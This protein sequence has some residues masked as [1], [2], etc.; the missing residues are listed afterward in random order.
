MVLNCVL[1]VTREAMDQQIK[2]KSLDRNGH[3]M[4]TASPHASHPQS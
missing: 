3:M 4:T 2:E 1:E